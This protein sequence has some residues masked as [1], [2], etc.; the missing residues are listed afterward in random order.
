MGRIDIRHAKLADIPILTEMAR[1]F[2]TESPIYGQVKFCDTY[3]EVAAELLIDEEKCCFLIAE[4][5]GEIVGALPGAVVDH[6]PISPELKLSDVAVFVRPDSRGAK[7]AKM[8][9]KAY[10]EW[11][12]KQGAKD[13]FLGVTTGHHRV[14]ALYER[15]GYNNVGGFYH[16]DLRIRST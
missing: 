4:R 13:S 16:K 10:E 5:N 12:V 3:F 8:L 6:Y 15:L 1:E 14:G 2:A 11:G 7:V 9:I